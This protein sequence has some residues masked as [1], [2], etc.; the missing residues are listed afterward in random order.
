MDLKPDNIIVNDVYQLTLIDWGLSCKSEHFMQVVLGTPE[1][2][3]PEMYCLN[4]YP[5]GYDPKCV[6]VFHL[7]V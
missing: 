2:L 1:Y 4:M 5:N 6:D 7:G 3:P